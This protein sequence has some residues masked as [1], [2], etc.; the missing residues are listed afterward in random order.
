MAQ[1]EIPRFGALLAPFIGQVPSAAL[2]RFLA[3]LERGAADRY[4]HWAALLP[5]HAAELLACAVSEDEIANRIEAVFTLTPELHDVVEAPLPGAL[6]TYAAAFDGLDV[7]DQLR[8]Q[9]NAERQ[10]AQAWRN[11]ASG[12]TDQATLA[13]IAACS[14]LEE[15]SADTLDRLITERAPTQ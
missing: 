8:I 11:I 13:A 5:E 10:G 4:R 7:W 3:L 14:A 1:L 12:V 15:V 6:A 2:P 9:A